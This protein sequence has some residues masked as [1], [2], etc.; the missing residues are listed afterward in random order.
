MYS[1]HGMTAFLSDLGFLGSQHLWTINRH[2]YFTVVINSHLLLHWIHNI[3]LWFFFYTLSIQS[4][5][6][7]MTSGFI[8]I[9]VHI[10]FLPPSLALSLPFPPLLP[11]FFP[12]FV[13]SFIFSSED[14]LMYYTK[15]LKTTQDLFLRAL[16]PGISGFCICGHWAWE[17]KGTSG[18]QKQSPIRLTCMKL[19]KA[20]M[21]PL[22][23]MNGE[24]ERFWS[25]AQ[26]MLTQTSLQRWISVARKT[27]CGRLGDSK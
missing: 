3:I 13:I 12:P 2:F 11:L 4:V 21:E 17:M 22:Q 14:P 16:T 26:E 18:D 1:H 5:F 27:S 7:L 15:C 25:G 23:Q 8:V 10:S 20:H 24:A 19:V 9:Y 6:F